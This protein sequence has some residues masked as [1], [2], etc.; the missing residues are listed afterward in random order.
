MLAFDVAVDVVVDNDVVVDVAAFD[1]VVDNDVVVVVVDVVAA[2]VVLVPVCSE[3]GSLSSSSLACT[4]R[5]CQ[6]CQYLHTY[7][8]FSK[9]TQ[10]LVYCTSLY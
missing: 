2:V 4:H 7:I 3:H 10:T 9:W 8:P 1:V 6:H 5:I